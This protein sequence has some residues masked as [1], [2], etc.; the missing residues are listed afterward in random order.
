MMKTLHAN[1]REVLAGAGLVLAA[2]VLP[3]Y[4]TAEGTAAA[5][6]ATVV[7]LDPRHARPSGGVAR[8]AGADARVVHL[9]ADPVRMW[10]GDLAPLLAAKSTRLLGMTTWPQFLIVRGLAEESGRRVRVQR[11]EAASGEISWLIA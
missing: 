5:S 8:L 7:L 10:R 6:P 2:S 3:A 11:V 9:E 1:R 4:A